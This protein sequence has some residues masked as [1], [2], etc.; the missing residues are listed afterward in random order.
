MNRVKLGELLK[1]KHG[2]AFKSE[3]YVPNSPYALVTLANISGTNN[4]KFDREKTTFYGANFPKEFM[5]YEGDLIMPLTEQVIGL[6]GNSAFVPAVDGIQFV[7]N[8]RVG[9]VIPIEGKADKKYLHFLLSTEIV[10]TQLEHRASGTKQRN[11]S[12]DDVYDVT[13]FVPEFDEQVRIGK[14]LYALE[15]KV[16]VNSAINDNL[17]QQLKLIYDYWFTQ[18][19]FPNK[20]GTPYKSSGGELIWNESLKRSI[21]KGWE[22]R[23]L[24]AI[25]SW[26]G[27]SQP[28]K[29]QHIGY[30]KIGYVRFIQNRDYAD[31]SHLTYI[32]I[33]RQNKLCSEYDIMVDKY[34]DA[35]K[36]RFGIAGA[37][38]VAL[39]RI[40]VNLQNGQE[41]VRSYLSSD[42]VKQYL[43]GACMAS[44]RASLNE[45]TMSFLNICIPTNEVLNK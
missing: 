31:N 2:Y 44:T 17:Q 6:F 43:S 28:P 9:K 16:N 45:D 5:L 8:Q 22:V 42:A 32:P 40:D 36:T 24:T 25:A 21:P 10:R 11:I 26:N 29:S 14:L 4:F 34:G 3:N 7:L 18:F 15:R 20:D 38:N 37:Y 27:G 30:E 23:S 35:G 19:N 12:P 1:V 41:Y 39:S 33:S 13:V